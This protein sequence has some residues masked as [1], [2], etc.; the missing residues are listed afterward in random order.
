MPENR[1][2]RSILRAKGSKKTRVMR[3]RRNANCRI[4]APGSMSLINTSDI[5][6]MA[7]PSTRMALFTVL[8]DMLSY[9]ETRGEIKRT[10]G[11]WQLQPTWVLISDKMMNIHQVLEK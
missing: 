3:Q 10:R 4:G 6:A 11:K 2:F 5:S 8:P 7:L 1:F 9:P